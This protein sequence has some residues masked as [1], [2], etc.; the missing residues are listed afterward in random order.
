MKMK[1]N[2]SV[3]N[4]NFRLMFLKGRCGKLLAV[5]NLTFAKSNGI[6][7][8]RISAPPSS[9]NALARTALEI[10]QEYFRDL[11]FQES[12]CVGRNLKKYMKLVMSRDK[13][14]KTIYI[15]LI[16]FNNFHWN[17]FSERVG[18]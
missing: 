15:K 9:S 6:G 8:N 13:E 5:Q 10:F 16:N 1:G 4:T 2:E 7:E 11:A 12:I 14:Y 17:L 18:S 3:S